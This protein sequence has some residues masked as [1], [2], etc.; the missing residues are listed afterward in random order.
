MEFGV[1]LP[2]MSWG[3]EDPATPA[4]LTAFTRR[5]DEL[6]FTW[7]TSND[8]L[9]YA[10]PWLDCLVTLTSVLPSS[11]T[12]TVGTTIA[13][14]VV[15]GPGPLAKALAAIDRFSD[16]RLVVGVGPGSSERDYRAM[17]IPWEERS[18]VQIFGRDYEA[19]CRQVR[20]RMFPGVY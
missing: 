13:L 7:V 4:G 11:G 8:H 10:R 2:L 19:Y 14:P 6:G 18:L 20:W 1:H 5:A 16:G 12:M 9:V 17:G 15:R 3:I